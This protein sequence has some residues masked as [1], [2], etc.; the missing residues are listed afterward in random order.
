MPEGLEA[1]EARLARD[2]AMLDYPALDWVKPRRSEDGS[3]ILDVAIVGGGQGGLVTAFGLMRERVTNIAVFDRAPAGREGPWRNFARMLTLRSPKS[4]TGPDLDMANLTFQAWFEAQHGRDAWTALNKVPT[5]DWAAYLAWYRRVL[6]IPV[7]HETD[8]VAIGPDAGALRLTLRDAAGERVVHARKIVLATGIESSGRWWTPPDVEALP[9]RWWAHSCETI[10]F[11]G[12]AGKRVAILGAGA[13]AFDNAATA[14]EAGAA[15]VDLYCRRPSLQR[16]QPFRWMSNHGFMRHVHTF[17][18][19]WRWR[20]MRYILELRESFPKETW[21]RVTRHGNFRLHEGSPWQALAVTGDGVAITTPK[22]MHRADFL[23]AAT[24]LDVELGRVP[25][26]APHAAA[27]AT[28]EDRYT[29]PAGEANPRLARYPY[30]GDGLAL[31]EKAPGTAPWLAG[32]HLFTWGATLS[33]GPSGSSINGMKFA[34][35]KLVDGIT[36]DLFVDDIDA[37]YRSLLAFDTPEFEID[38][39]LRRKVIDAT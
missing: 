27:I 23:I 28:W 30:L 10:D 18:D 2:L 14:L 19:A 9:K 35:P 31:Q 16:L 3:R 6:G 5:P 20:F 12:L 34:V 1:L 22:A 4:T 15:H 7:V 25:L 36:R 39:A 32:I 13:S 37:H 11:A 17:D 29:P 38:A 24:G 33:F 21:E 8:I 26:L